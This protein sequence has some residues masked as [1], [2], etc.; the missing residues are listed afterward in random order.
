MDLVE[1][2]T[3]KSVCMRFLAGKVISEGAFKSIM[4]ERLHI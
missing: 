4:L 3:V 1:H 2:R